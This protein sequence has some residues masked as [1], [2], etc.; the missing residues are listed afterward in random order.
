MWAGLQSS[1]DLESYFVPRR[2]LCPE[3][4]QCEPDRS[5]RFL[6][7]VGHT[8][9]ARFN[10]KQSRSKLGGAGKW[11]VEKHGTSR[12]RSWRKLHIGID[13]GSGDIVA[14]ELTEKD[15]SMTLRAPAHCSTRSAIQSHRSPR[16]EPMI[17][18]ECMRRSPSVIQ[19]RP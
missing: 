18:T 6:E 11:L 14:I 7:L 5:R 15:V 19:M 9:P 13:A 17:R 16:T 3:K 2:N 8:G 12:R 1:P 10:L 4:S